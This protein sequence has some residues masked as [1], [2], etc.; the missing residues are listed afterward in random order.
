[1]LLL[2]GHVLAESL[3]FLMSIREMARRVSPRPRKPGTIRS[4]ITRHET[5]FAILG[6]FIVFVGFIVK[7]GVRESYKDLAQELEQTKWRN[8]VRTGLGDI[9]MGVTDLRMKGFYREF[10]SGD[11]GRPRQAMEAALIRM[12]FTTNMDSLNEATTKL[13]VS[14]MLLE[15]LPYHDPGLEL[16]SQS[17]IPLTNVEISLD[18]QE[19]SFTEK[20]FEIESK[21]ADDSRKVIAG[22]VEKE[23]R[24]CDLVEEDAA[25][26]LKEK[27]DRLKYATVWM[28]ILFVV[29]WGLG[30]LGKILKIPALGGVS[31]G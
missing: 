1:M 22:L 26:Q 21:K 13:T 12:Q 27:A 6:A 19:G 3:E 15:E 25:R 23:T 30:L 14:R 18:L 31:E 24:F 7:E 10:H 17:L 28:Y 8:E 4:F 29:G 16:L 11:L 9:A 5:L 2:V 20:Q